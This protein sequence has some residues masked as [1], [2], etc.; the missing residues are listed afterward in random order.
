MMPAAQSCVSATGLTRPKAMTL[1]HGHWMAVAAII[2]VGA[3]WQATHPPSADVSWLIVVG[4]KMLA[5]QQLYKEVLELNPPMSVF[6]YVP[7][8]WLEHLTGLSAEAWVLVMTFGLIAAA[9]VLLAHIMTASGQGDD[10]P[11]TVVVAA[12]LLAVAPMNV[13]AEREHIAVTLLLPA[14]ALALGQAHGYRPG[15]ILRI[16]IGLLSGLIV[17]IKPH[18]GLAILLP[19]LYLAL[20][21]RSWRI[22]FSLENLIASAF[23]L[24]YVAVVF[25]FF[26]IYLTDV[27]PL[28][29]DTYRVVRFSLWELLR[30]NLELQIVVFT[31][32]VIVFILGKDALKPKTVIPLLATVGLIAAFLEQGKG[33]VYHLYPA[34]VGAFLL[35]GGDPLRKALGEIRPTPRSILTIVFVAASFAGASRIV[36]VMKG[37]DAFETELAPYVAAHFHHPRL[38]SLGRSLGLGHPLTRTVGGI[39]VGTSA[40]GIVPEAE[41]FVDDRPGFSVDVRERIQHWVAWEREVLAHDLRVG[42]PDVILLNRESYPY[43]RLMAG[44]SEAARYLANYS[45]LKS[46]YGVDI[47]VPATSPA[48]TVPGNTRAD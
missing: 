47:L 40:L 38:L 21:L 14:L 37:R 29:T 23:V 44:N 8:I 12:I 48:L 20:R 35:F 7:A 28:L 5:G 46:M 1:R 30:T 17:S 24:T 27:V 42:Q 39:W 18:F 13:F 6:L 10:V 36:S 2:L 11:R 4:E 25:V 45:V 9:L 19:Y 15:A 22:L 34:F 41:A 43:D 33:W 3:L 16:A 26:R 31:M 32:G